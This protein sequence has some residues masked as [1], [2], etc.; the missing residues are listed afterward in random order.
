LQQFDK[1]YRARLRTFMSSQL[2]ALGDEGPPPQRVHI[3]NPTPMETTGLIPTIQ[4]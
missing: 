2:R 3:D 4:D 1:D